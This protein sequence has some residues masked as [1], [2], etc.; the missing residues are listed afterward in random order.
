MSCIIMTPRIEEL[1]TEI[2][3]SKARTKG[4]IGLWWEANPSKRAEEEY[5]SKTELTS[6]IKTLDIVPNLRIATNTANVA[7]QYGAI[8]TLRHPN[9]EGMHFGN[10]FSHK[11]YEGVKKVMP[12][13]KDAVTAFEEW[14]RGTKYQDIEPERRQWIL[15]RIESGDLDGRELVYYTEKIPDNDTSYGVDTYDYY[16]APNHAHVLQRLILESKKRRDELKNRNFDNSF[17]TPQIT[18]VEEQKEVDRVFDPIKRR[19][20][21]SLIARHFSRIVT[22]KLKEMKDSI[23]KRLMEDPDLSEKDKEDLRKELYKLSRWE[24]IKQLKPYN[25]FKEVLQIFQDYVNLSEAARIQLELNAINTALSK[26]PKA[27][28]KFSNEQKLQAAKKKATYKFNEYQKLIKHFK[29]LA[30]E[31][32]TTLL[33]SE[34][35]RIDINYLQPRNTAD[36]VE[37]DP[38]GESSLDDLINNTFE[39]NVKDGWMTNFRQVSSHESLSQA[40]RKAISEIPMLNYKG[41]YDKDDLGNIQYMD[42]DY[43]HAVLIDSLKNMIT[44][45]DMIPM[46]EKLAKTK[47][48]V[49]QIIKTLQKDETLFSQFYQDFRKDFI[50]YWVQ[51][52]VLGYDGSFR[53]ET[54]AVNKPEGVYYLLDSWRDNYENGI[55][56][57]EDSIYAKDG[58]LSKSHAKT[59]LNI[60]EDL[61]EAINNINN[62]DNESNAKITEFLLKEG[63]WNRIVKLLNMIGIDPN[64]TVLRVALTEDKSTDKVHYTHPLTLLL[65]QLHVI[66]SKVSKGDV[67]NKTLEDGTETRRDLINNFGRVYNHIAKLISDVIKD[68]IES[69]IREADKSYYAHVMPSYIGKLIKLLKNVRGESNEEYLKFLK[70]EFGN[71]EWFFRNGRWMSDWL[72]VLADNED[73]ERDLLQHKVVLNH[74]KTEYVDWDDLTHALVLISEFFSDPNK[75]TAWY[76]MPNLSDAPSAEFIK[77]KRYSDTTA[78]TYKE[79]ILPKLRDVVIQ[80]YNRIMLVRERG[81]KIKNGDKSVEPIANFDMTFKDNGRVKNKGGAEFKFFPQLN[82]YKINGK[83]FIEALADAYQSSPKAGEDLI[84]GVL[85]DIMNEQF[86]ETYQQWVNLGLFEETKDGK[87]YRNL[88]TMFATQTASNKSLIAALQRAKTILKEAFGEDENALLKAL[89]NKEIWSLEDIESVLEG[90]RNLIQDRAAKNL[91]SAK[92]A[93]NLIKDLRYKNPTRDMLEEYYWNNALA[94]TQIIELSTTDLAFY[95]NME[96]FQKRYKEVHAPALRLNTQATFRGEKVGREWE[97]TIY[98]KDEEIISEIIKDLDEILDIKI[99]K[100]ELS[101]VEKDLIISKYKSVNVADAQAYRSLSSYRAIMVMSGQWTDEMELAY[102][103]LKDPDANGKWDIRDFNVIWQT[104]KPFVFTQVNNDSGVTGHTGIK[105]PVQHKNSEF[106]LLAMYDAV[107]NSMGRS[108]KLRAINKFME[109]NQIDVVQ[110]ESTTKVGKQGT[111]NL[112]DVH[113]YNEVIKRLEEATGVKTTEN[114]NVVHT[115]SYEDY[116]IQQSTPEHIIGTTQLIGTQIRKLITADMSDDIKITVGTGDKAV[117]KTKKEW[118]DLYN[119]INTENIIESFKAVNEMF[120]DIKKIEEVLLNEIRGNTRYSSD[121]IR[122]CTI[123]PKTGNFT[124]PLF[125]PVQSQRIQQL[126]NSVI[127]KEITKQ[128]ITGGSLIQVS[129]Y[130]LTDDLHIVFEGEGEKKRIKYVECYMP[131]YAFEFYDLLRDENGLLDANKL[132]EELRRAIGYRV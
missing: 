103:H 106:L 70:E 97:R 123:D 56:L 74:D 67:K 57:D 42:A 128:K 39:E 10:P 26:N 19:N 50:Q 60:V 53:I 55:L 31:A 36:N 112:S 125:D 79:I 77:F 82:S 101:K 64:P 88:P 29:A 132:P 63:N 30:E 119:A 1:A 85:E 83:F 78:Q 117:T 93:D 11:N 131:A 95:K 89:N 86:E 124:I 120:S 129:D 113:G 90:I 100:G 27:A 25:I 73:N 16:G 43:V 2:G 32:S 20:R 104:K 91:I 15:D 62:D 87:S 110:F 14:L 68:A 37:A 81:K 126:L 54:I 92:D 71:Y 24:V 35:L 9:K 46:L 61:I 65:D 107:A 4:L 96:D 34:G 22:K 58:T 72:Q 127:K 49:R 13:V 52:K 7:R 98:L 94:T 3:E 33:K 84:E 66:M 18:S 47:V 59:G 41:V 105:T 6:F 69:N 21:V 75:S 44:V 130:G 111:I 115:V 118:L 122:A 109:D 17:D 108:S 76:A 114:P 80:E 5:P 51:K 99:A 38:E 23:D 40:V 8:D 48:W 12:T 28:A 121:L 45:S 116:G 102:K